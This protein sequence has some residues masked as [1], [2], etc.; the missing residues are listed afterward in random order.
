MGGGEYQLSFESFAHDE[1]VRGIAVISED[2]FATSSRD[3]TVKLWR[4]T[5]A[6]TSAASAAG[7]EFGLDK[8]LVGHTSFVGPLAWIP[9]RQTA[10]A[11]GGGGGGGEGT[12][13]AAGAGKGVLVS[14]GMDCLVLVWDLE[15]GEVAQRLAGHEQQVTGVTATAAGDIA[16]CSVDKSI[17]VWRD[18]HCQQQLSGHESSVLCLA[19]A[20]N[21]LLFSGSGD[22]TIRCW[23]GSS[24]IKSVRAHSDSV[25]GL[26]LLP[27]VGLLSA[28]HDGS[29]KLWDLSLQPLLEMVGHT[30][31][32]YSVAATAGGELIASGS[33]DATARVWRDG[34]CMQV[35]E[36]PSCVWAVAFLP[37]G[38]LITASADGAIR[39]WTRDSARVAPEGLR[40]TY[41]ERVKSCRKKKTVGGVNVDELPGIEALQQPGHKDGQTL[42]VRENDV[43]V[44]Y[45][46]SHKEFN[47]E[48]IGEVVDG[49]SEPIDAKMFEGKQYDYVFDVDIGDGVPVRKLPYNHGD[50]PY[51]VADKWLLSQDLPLG[52]REQVVDFILRNTGQANPMPLGATIPD[53][54]TG[55]QAYVPSATPSWGGPAPAARA[56]GQPSPAAPAAAA[57]AAA[58]AQEKLFPK[59]G[60][61]VFDSAQYDGIMKKLKEFNTT[62]A[63]QSAQS[64]LSAEQLEH[65]DSLVSVLK[66]TSHYHSSSFAPHHYALISSLLSSWP[67]ANLFPVLDLLRMMLLHPSAAAWFSANASGPGVCVQSPVSAHGMLMAAIRRAAAEPPTP[68]NHLTGVRVAVNVFGLPSLH[69]WPRQHR[70]EVLDLF[71]PCAAS[72]N[73]NVRLALATLLLNYAVLLVDKTAAAAAGEDLEE[74]QVQ[75][76]SAAFELAAASEA[77]AEVRYRALLAIATLMHSGVVRDTA[78]EMGAAEVVQAAAAATATN[79]L[80]QL[81][82]EMKSLIT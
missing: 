23:E 40:A 68:A 1:D 30:A 70:A 65:L 35:L 33:E 60:Y 66:D 25:R 4:R 13:D 2:C 64:A 81:G 28:S 36:H 10:A 57:T 58:P 31:L 44:A 48:R 26:A 56:P 79:A 14:G 73:K 51:D 21:G 49:P 62:L 43:G 76:L 54:Y 18:G 17:R 77:D 74:G 8:T 19:A 9:G 38:D 42:I 39:I 59:R 27:A 50:N 46:W 82:R 78:V 32:V 80:P 5:P 53:P 22:C 34:E 15:T 6:S 29:V 47:W 52:Y 37:S 63:T 75:T 72:S 16:T 3:K 61:L 55:G 67:S 12:S 41:E 11:A 71:A 69:H 45:Q 24:C 7:S 20:A